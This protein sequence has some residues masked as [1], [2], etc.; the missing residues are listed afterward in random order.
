MLPIINIEYS[1]CSTKL[2]HNYFGCFR[3]PCN[4]YTTL[5]TI[6]VIK[7][8]PACFIIKIQIVEEILNNSK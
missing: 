8:T 7:Q 3:K 5:L 1:G 6:L 2:M 4:N